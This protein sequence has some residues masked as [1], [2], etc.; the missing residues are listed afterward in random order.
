MFDGGYD[1]S[2]P[3]PYHQDSGKAGLARDHRQKFRSMSSTFPWSRPKS[4]SLATAFGLDDAPSRTSEA[5]IEDGPDTAEP[6][7]AH[8]SAAHG[9]GFRSMVRRASKTIRGIVNRRPSAAAD[10]ALG[11]NRH[12]GMRPGTSH[13]LWTGKLK[14]RN[15]SV[16]HSRS[17]Y[18]LDYTHEPLSIIDSQS[19][20]IH[21]F[22]PGPSFGPPIIPENTG[23]AAK[24]SAAMQ[25]EY[26]ASLQ[27]KQL[28]PSP[29]E[30]GNDRESGIGIALSVPDLEV[31]ISECGTP[32]QYISKVDFISQLP[33]ELA[34]HVLA[35]LDA[36]ALS[37]ASEVSRDWNKIC[38]NQH[39]WRESC[40]REMTTTYATSGPVKPNSGF[41]IPPN[42]PSSNW[43]EIYRAKQ[44]LN[45]R[46]KSGKAQPIYL[47]G[48]KDSIYCVQFDEYVLPNFQH[49]RLYFANLD[50]GTN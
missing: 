23:A 30:D 11:S 24:A 46:W 49:G 48:H 38:S 43:K 13:S 10:E 22:K 27:S 45:Q 18:G 39:V 5:V 29:S 12:S 36:Q 7:G 47:N 1:S 25:N 14:A 16:H 17:F 41:G 3:L 19:R 40:L 35:S 8:T 2:A 20:D 9:A 28:S 50:S 31:D 34:I 44:E 6:H 21:T 37:R 32:E 42:N 26:L 33:L 4:S 15:K